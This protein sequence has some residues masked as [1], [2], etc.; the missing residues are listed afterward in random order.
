VREVAGEARQ[1]LAEQIVDEFE[2]ARIE[3]QSV[4]PPCSTSS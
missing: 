2:G 3:G 1:E 4:Q